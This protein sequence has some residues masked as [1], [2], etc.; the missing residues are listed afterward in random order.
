MA[1]VPGTGYAIPA[2]GALAPGH[3]LVVPERHWFSTSSISVSATAFAAFVL[4]VLGR[5]ESYYGPATIFEHGACALQIR[6]S[7]CVTHAHLQILPGKYA[8]HTVADTVPRCSFSSIA[9]FIGSGV[10]QRGYLMYQEP[11]DSVSYIPDPAVS[12]LVRRHVAAQVGR[13]TEWDYLVFQN[14]DTIADTIRNLSSLKD[15]PVG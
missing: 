3:L 14:H 6:R 10:E 8:L 4:E 15:V 12:Q 13:P 5:V 7:A 11:G 1:A 2:L 9:D